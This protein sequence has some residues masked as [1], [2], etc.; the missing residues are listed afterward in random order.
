MQLPYDLAWVVCPRFLT[1]IWHGRFLVLRAVFKYASNY[2][3]YQFYIFSII[4]NYGK[5]G[6]QRLKMGKQ[7]VITTTTIN[8]HT[9]TRRGIYRHQPLVN[10]SFLYHERQ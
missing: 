8:H 9:S 2:K 7:C 10:N 4:C 1:L 5:A 6:W 3:K